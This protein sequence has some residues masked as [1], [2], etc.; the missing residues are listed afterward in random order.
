M[1]HRLAVGPLGAHGLQ[2]IR[3]KTKLLSLEY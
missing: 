2:N 1:Q 3:P